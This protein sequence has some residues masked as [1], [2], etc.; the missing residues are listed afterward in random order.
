MRRSK[1]FPSELQCKSD[2]KCFVQVWLS[3]SENEDQKEGVKRKIKIDF[4]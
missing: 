4:I 3:L 2:R 1:F